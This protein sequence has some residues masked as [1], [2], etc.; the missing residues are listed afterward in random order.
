M[1]VFI[2]CREELGADRGN[3]TLLGSL[4]GY[5]ITTMLCPHSV[6]MLLR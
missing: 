6:A 4:E 2:T 3:R 5:C 1:T